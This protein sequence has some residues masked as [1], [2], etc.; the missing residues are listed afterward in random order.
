MHCQDTCSSWSASIECLVNPSMVCQVPEWSATSSR[1]SQ[2]WM[3]S[4]PHTTEN[5][6][7]PQFAQCRTKENNQ[8]TCPDSQFAQGCN[9]QAAPQGSWSQEEKCTLGA[10]PLD[11]CSKTSQSGVFQSSLGALVK[12]WQCL[13]CSGSR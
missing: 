5:P 2:D 4:V 13:A 1:C 8:S 9:S 7:S 11:S 3:T 10:T 12:V 6:A